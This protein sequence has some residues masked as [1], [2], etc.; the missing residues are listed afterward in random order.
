MRRK[1]PEREVI[2]F[3]A[4]KTIERSLENYPRPIFV[5]LYSHSHIYSM[6]I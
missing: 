1:K 5:F 4:R 6:W 3:V 2:F